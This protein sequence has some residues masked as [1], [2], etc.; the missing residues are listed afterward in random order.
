MQVLAGEVG[1]EHYKD[2]IDGEEVHRPGKEMPVALGEPEPGRTKRR[3][4]GGGDGNSRHHGTLFL[5]CLFKNPGE[6]AE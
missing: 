1:G 5:A 6:S 4:E 3:H 2:R